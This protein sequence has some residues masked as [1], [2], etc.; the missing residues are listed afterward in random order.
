MH[1]DV[2]VGAEAMH[3]QAEQLIAL[4][5]THVAELDE[6]GGHWITLLDPEGTSCASSGDRLPFEPAGGAQ[7]EPWLPW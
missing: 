4:G 2:D 5:A 6:P 1:L 3:A 7:S